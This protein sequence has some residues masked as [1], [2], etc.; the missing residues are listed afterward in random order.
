MKWMISI[1]IALPAICAGQGNL[2][3]NGSFEDVTSCPWESGLASL[4]FPWAP[5][6]VLQIFL[7]C[8][9]WEPLQ[10]APILGYQKI[11][12]AISMLIQ[13]KVM[14]A[15]SPITVLYRMGGNICRY[16]YSNL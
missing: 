12:R 3:P 10:A 7:M 9:T 13:A 11:L 2:V 16:N 4:A 1:L 5:S 8:V 15:Y 14:W 6:P